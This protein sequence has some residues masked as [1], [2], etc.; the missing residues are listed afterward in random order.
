[1]F[2]FALWDA[3]RRRLLLARDRLGIKPL[4]YAITPDGLAFASEA[5][6]LVE[7]RFLATRLDPVA[8]GRLFRYGFVLGSH[9]F[10]DGIRR[11]SPGHRLIHEAGRA[12]VEPYWDVQFPEPGERPRRSAAEW[13][14]GLLERLDLAVRL[15]LRS[16]VPLGA[17]LSTG[18]D[19]SAVVALAARAVGGSIRA[20]SLEFD[21][22]VCDE[23]RGAS[24]LASFPGFELDGGRARCGMEDFRLYP[25]ALWHMEEPSTRG[26]EVARLVLARATD[27]K[28][29]LTGEGADEALAGYVWYRL[30]AVYR[31]FSRW[32]RSVRE[33]LARGAG[34]SQGRPWA[35]RL[36]VAPAEI[37]LAR[38]AALMGPPHPAIAKR[39]FSVEF[40]GRMA[41]L[42]EEPHCDL[43][44]SFPRWH[45]LERLQYLELKT[46]LPDYVNQV[47]DRESMACSVEARLPFLDHELVE[48]C[49][50]IPPRLKLHR[51]R[52]KQVLRRALRTVLPPE[53]VRRRKRPLSAPYREWLRA[54]KPEFAQALLAEESLREKGYFDPTAVGQMV[55]AH[56]SRVEDYGEALLAVLAVQVWDEIF[57]RGW[58]PAPG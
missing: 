44:P 36:L 42:G 24:T 58:R 12:R 38:Y 46:R 52:E 5:K 41:E 26:V 27:R 57:L 14:E 31:P 55:A 49:A 48:Y 6:A 7:S 43:P 32:P 18:I 47:L 37:G 15:H 45:P 51:L 16:D 10:F 25:L 56:R 8:V 11:L 1:M 40:G 20:L 28:V 33:A 21:D 17:W 29:V 9:T 39:L 50:Q 19:S 3:P 23:V 34:L 30:D 22:P 13:S 35:S 2:G 4:V 53:I 54:E